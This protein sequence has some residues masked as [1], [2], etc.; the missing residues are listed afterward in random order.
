MLTHSRDRKYGML[1][2]RRHGCAANTRLLT[3]MAVTRDA[4]GCRKGIA[5]QELHR[6]MLQ[7]AL[8]FPSMDL[9]ARLRTVQMT[10]K[11][12]GLLLL[13]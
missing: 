2:S 5:G 12:G 1:N 11:L 6:K 4:I 3:A 8:G 13:H 9:L 7:N 10:R